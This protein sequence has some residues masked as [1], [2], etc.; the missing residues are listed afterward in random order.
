MAIDILTSRLYQ[1]LTL[2]EF[3]ESLESLPYGRGEPAEF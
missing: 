3:L 2:R 1:T